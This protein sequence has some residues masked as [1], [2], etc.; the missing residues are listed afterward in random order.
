M[1]YH[2]NEEGS[3]VTTN[4]S[5]YSLPSITIRREIGGTIYTVTGSFDGTEPAHE[6]LKRIAA[7]NAVKNSS[8]N[9]SKRGGENA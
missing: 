6:K 1:K 2:F 5:A 3:I 9:L 8:Q 4:P 7:E